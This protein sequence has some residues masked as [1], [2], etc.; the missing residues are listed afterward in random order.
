MLWIWVLSTIVYI[1]LILLTIYVSFIIL[2]YIG[3][4]HLWPSGSDLYVASLCPVLQP[5]HLL[6][7]HAENENISNA[8]TVS[9]I[10]QDNI[11]DI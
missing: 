4:G 6:Y 11:E 1:T 5:C 3:N 7:H 2:H 10:G 8:N 9:N